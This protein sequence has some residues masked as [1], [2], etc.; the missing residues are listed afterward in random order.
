MGFFLS[1]RGHRSV[2]EGGGAA[3]GPGEVDRARLLGMEP[4][5]EGRAPQTLRAA[6]AGDQRE[7]GGPPPLSGEHPDQR[8]QLQ[9]CPAGAGAAG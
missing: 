4:L 3:G 8:T 1:A 6:G 7:A 5:P 2:R 9:G